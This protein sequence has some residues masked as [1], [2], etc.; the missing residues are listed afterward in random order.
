MED[1]GPEP[2]YEEK[3]RAHLPRYYFVWYNPMINKLIPFENVA[4]D[5][6]VGAYF[7]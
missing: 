5:G 6:T 4:G 3:M 2:T 7:S 1:V